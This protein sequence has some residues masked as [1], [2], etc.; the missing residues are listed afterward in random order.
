MSYSTYLRDPLK[1]D[2]YEIYLNEAQPFNL[3]IIDGSF[4]EIWNAW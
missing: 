3:I 1:L 2:M 4:Q